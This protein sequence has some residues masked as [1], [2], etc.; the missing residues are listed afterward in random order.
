MINKITSI[1][2]EKIKHLRK[3]NQVKYR[4][5]FGQFFVENVVII[6]DALL[7]GYKYQQLFVTPEFVDKNNGLY[8]EIVGQ[9]GEKEI[10]IIDEKINKSFSNLD[11]APGI[12]AVYSVDEK[13]FSMSDQII[14]LNNISIPGNL[15]GILRSA[16]AFG[17]NN[18]VLDKQCVD[19]YNYK[20]IQAA[21]E[22]IFK[23]NINIDNDGSILKKIK[24]N[25]EVYST[26]LKGDENVLVNLK[27]KDKFCLVFGNESHG[28]DKD[29]L[30][31]SDKLVKIKISDEIESLNV[32]N[33]AA[34]IF[35]ELFKD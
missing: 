22:A 15:G 7:G 34:I 27:N 33:S 14:Y 29:I 28:V 3:L 25:M 20:V 2:N 23:L 31:L 32:A 19:M 13:K 4:K 18:I 35:Y 26:S 21:K 24:N 17:F 10:Y 9:A 1:D 5:E 30:E 11:T 16:L 6:R 12:C 8:K